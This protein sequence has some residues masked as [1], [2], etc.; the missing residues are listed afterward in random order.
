MT[1]ASARR[2]VCFFNRSYWPDTGA[3]GQLLTELAEGLAATHRFDVTVVCGPPLT[4]ERLPRSAVHNGVRIVRASG[5]RFR[6][7]RFAG[8]AANYLTYFAS[9]FIAGRRLPR[10]DVVVALTDPP[11]IGL[12]A[13][14]SQARARFVFYCQDVFPEV[15]ALL[16]DFRSPM[17]DAI[18]THVNRYLVRRADRVIALDD[19]MRRRL[20]DSKGA[21][22]ARVSVIHNWADPLMFI[23]APRDN[24]FVAGHQ[25]EKR[26]VVLHAGNIGFSQ[27]LDIVL[28]A[29]TELRD[30]PDV[31]FLFVGNGTSRADLSRAV[32]DRGLAHT[33]RFLPYQQREEMRWSYAAA[34]VCLISL[35]AGLSGVIVPSKLYSILAAGKPFVAAIDE[36][37]S[38]A[39]IATEH[40]CGRV[41]QPGDAA[42]LARAIRE[43]AGNRQ[44]LA[45]MGCRA[46]M[47]AS[48]F[49]RDGQI[50]AHASLLGALSA[51]R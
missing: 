16:E 32:E 48:A 21:D 51:T 36:D 19:T 29:A 35:R 27:N 40:D 30:V 46:R 9:A 42:G 50:A 8:R 7:R 45:A 5:T 15:A 17:A 47:A 33:V 22:A 24:P 31:L 28:D 14:W 1:H 12:A 44:A 3:T 26:F 11:I 37:S 2:R 38:V 41:V 10:Q 23:D 13:A 20:V 49:T 43:L 25:L 4:G 18:L 6:P 39:R 34:D